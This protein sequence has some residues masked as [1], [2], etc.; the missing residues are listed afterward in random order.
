MNLILTAVHD[1]CADMVAPP[2][3]KFKAGDVIISKAGNKYKLIKYR[4]TADTFE[5][6]SRSGNLILHGKYT[7][8]QLEI[9]GVKRA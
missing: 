4:K 7:Q 8:R 2:L 3:E 5:L 9:A 6:Q 1:L